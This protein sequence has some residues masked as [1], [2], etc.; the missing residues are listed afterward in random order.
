MRAGIAAKRVVLLG[1]PVAHSI[2]PRFQQAAFDDLGLDVVY[3]AWDTL[4]AKLPEHLAR[5]RSQ[6]FLGANVTVPHKQQAL[7]LV[8]EASDDAHL[9]GAT[10]CLVNAGGQLV[11]HNTDVGGFRRALRDQ[12]SFDARGCRV[13]I[14]GAGGAARAVA[15]AL[16]R[17]GA[18]AITV[19]NRSPERAAEL[20]SDL[21]AGIGIPM[22]AGT[23]NRTGRVQ[24]S[25]CDLLVN[26]TSLGMAG[27]EFGGESPLADE[28]LP[29]GAL[30]V[31]VVA[32]PIWTP[33]LI[34]AKKRAC[35]TLGGLAML[36]YQ[37]ALAF[38]LWTDREAPVEVMMRTA[39]AAMGLDNA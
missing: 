4:E 28:S 25:D 31:D 38:N 8:D 6:E 20:V 34:Q 19:L 12:A 26:C 17:E 30:V 10:N 7:A 36:V 24:I 35:R 18:A 11:G 21:Q 15:V 39:R 9:T 29:D 37:G 5:L 22:Q 23:L 32:N 33:L 1:H 3:E 13:A 2:S 27:T 16:G 14:L